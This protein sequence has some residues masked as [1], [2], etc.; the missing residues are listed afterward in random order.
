MD[1]LAGHYIKVGLEDLLNR[2]P[3]VDLLISIKGQG[4]DL[5]NIKN[6]LQVEVYLFFNLLIVDL[7]IPRVGIQN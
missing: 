2:L 5:G 4:L 1:I 7:K 3:V 6:K